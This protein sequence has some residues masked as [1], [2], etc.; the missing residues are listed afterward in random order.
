MNFQNIPRKDKVVKA[1]FRPKLDALMFFDYKQIEYRILAYY[2]AMEAGDMR[3]AEDFKA[4][5]DPHSET[6]RLMLGIEDDR[7]LED[8]E[9]Q[10]GKTG[11]FSIMY[12]GGIPT[13]M[14][15]L[16]C[17][18]RRAK[19]LLFALRDSMPGIGQI[20]ESIRE[21]LEERGKGNPEKGWITTLAGRQ[22][23]PKPGERDPSRLLFNGLIQ[24]G[25]AEVMRDG[26]IR[27]HDGLREQGLSG[28]LVNVV[29]DE[30]CF[31]VPSE[32]L[33]VLYKSVPVYMDPYPHV[34]EVVPVEV[35][36]E[37]SFGTW[38]DKAAYRPDDC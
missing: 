33:P 3:M 27:V 37:V 4:G 9:R 31:D 22:L 10:V 19:E 28:H 21:V 35:D 1:A 8:W 13:L 5:R 36:C 23:H 20:Q 6:A 38:A 15:Q 14:R 11:N 12:L 32:E 26:L 29:H 34:S 25:A 18:A 30:F 2:L 7:P 16:G 24:G 17:D